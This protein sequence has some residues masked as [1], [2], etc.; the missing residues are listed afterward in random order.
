MLWS[1]LWSLAFAD[2]GMWLP[3][4]MTELGPAWEQRGLSLDADQLADPLGHPLGAVVSLGFR[5]ASFVSDQGLVAT[6]HHC[7]SSYLQYLSSADAPHH[8]DGFTAAS[9]TDEA[10]VGPGARMW[11]VEDIQDVTRDVLRRVG[12]GT[13]DA[14]RYTRIQDAIK[15]LIADCESEGRRCTVTSQFGGSRYDL[16][17]ALE[18][19]DV[20]LVF[21]PPHAVGQFGGDI[22][23][24]Q[25][26]RHSADFA[27]LRAYVGPDGRPADFSPDNIP[28]E[29]PHHLELDTD[30][31]DPGD[32]VMV[33]GFPG[34]TARHDLVR[35]TEDDLGTLMPEYLERADEALAILRKHRASSDEANARLARAESSLA[36]GEKKTRGILDGF[37]RE[38]TLDQ[39]RADE[40]A[41]LAWIDGDP[42]RRALRAVHAEMVAAWESD[43][44]QRQQR[45]TTSRL[46]RYAPLLSNAHRALRLADERQKPDAKRRR[47]YQERDIARIRAA[48]ERL[49]RSLWLPAD[50]E[51]LTTVFE[52]YLAL[53]GDDRLPAIDAWLD[54]RGGLE[55]ALEALYTDPAL[56]SVDA[57]LALLEATPAAL[58]TS[59]D[60]WVQLAV[61]LETWMGPE[62]LAGDALRGRDQRLWSQWI[63]AK[64][65]WYRE[66]GRVLSDDANSTLRLTLGHVQGYAPEDGLQ[67]LPETTLSG[68]VAK[69]GDAPFDAPEAFVTR[70]GNA[71][72]SRWADPDHGDVVVNVLTTLDVTGGNSGSATLNGDGELVGLAFDTTW[73]GVVSDRHFL[74]ERTRTIVVDVRYML[75]VVEGDEDAHWLLDELGVSLP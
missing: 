15:D 75:W 42:S 31:V 74:A 35:E 24:W 49:D 37:A 50:R 48:A 60:P 13:S 2:G 41:M 64:R 7:V 70:A 61:A 51:L 65:D 3:E 19:R 67:A 59:E 29:P 47:G 39:L 58:R 52:D 25:W 44:A 23:N 22:D 27:F 69:A 1:M 43:F 56:A 6:N 46:L 32:F 54:A 21:A 40:E 36:N 72:A 73:E 9:R 38:G 53:P 57:R 26:P 17:S 62:R 8:R 68:L 16:I 18:L 30:G 12:R 5:S 4:Q 71:S 20:R 55:G 33:A 63:P 28:Y 10:N 11:V 66:T 45:A 14:K 34:R